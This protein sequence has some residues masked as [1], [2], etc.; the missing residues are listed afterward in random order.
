[1]NIFS[2]FFFIELIK[3]EYVYLVWDK[4]YF[5]R[6]LKKYKDFLSNSTFN[7]HKRILVALRNKVQYLNN[8][9]ILPEIKK[10]FG[11]LDL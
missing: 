6:L 3:D 9:N 11:Y 7:K 4:E 10:L 5:F 2:N 8:D 1:M